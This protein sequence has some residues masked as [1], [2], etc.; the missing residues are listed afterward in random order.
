VTSPTY[1]FVNN[2]FK[3]SYEIIVIKIE[4]SL[5]FVVN[6]KL[7]GIFKIFEKVLLVCP[8]GV[9]EFP[10]FINGCTVY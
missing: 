6:I 1:S 10:L 2:K 8:G 9:V 3:Y 4:E 5:N 7:Y